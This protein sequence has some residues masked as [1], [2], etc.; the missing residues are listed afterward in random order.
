METTFSYQRTTG[1]LLKHLPKPT[2]SIIIMV[3]IQNSFVNST[4]SYAKIIHFSATRCLF[5]MY[6]PI[7]LSFFCKWHLLIEAFNENSQYQEVSK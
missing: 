1:F 2:S 5:S 6:Y 4:R 3:V 7:K